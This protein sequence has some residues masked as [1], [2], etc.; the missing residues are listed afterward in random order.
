MPVEPC[1]LDVDPTRF[2]QVVSNLVH[3]A[4]KFTPAGG[5]ILVT[6]RVESGDGGAP[7]MAML[8]VTDTGIGIA[9]DFVP[10]VFDLF[11][12][13]DRASSQPGLG[14]GLTLA[15]RLIEM[16]DGQITV[17]SEGLGH[18]SEFTVRLPLSSRQPAPADPEPVRD[19]IQCRVLV[20]DDNRDAAFVTSLLIDELGGESRTAHDAES[21]LEVMREFKPRVVLVDIGMP[22]IDGYE[23][24]R[25]IRS[26]VGDGVTVV[27]LT[28]FGQDQDKARAAHAGFDG[29]LTKPADPKTL[30]R[31]L[32]ECSV[33]RIE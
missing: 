1:V 16:H 18:G 4:V 26:E 23:T 20:I 6:A 28:G 10:Y 15:R 31:L 24:C 8:S 21:G 2:L 17:R 13:G 29:H 12:Q 19:E 33:P 7:P 3:N 32:A 30:V 22:H 11:T 5:T 9:P 25:R 27:A 14:I